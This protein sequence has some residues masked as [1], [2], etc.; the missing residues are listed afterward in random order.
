MTPSLECQEKEKE[1]PGFAEEAHY[2]HNVEAYKNLIRPYIVQMLESL[3]DY[4]PNK[5]QVTA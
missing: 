2:K 1:N 4:K 3:Q 5:D